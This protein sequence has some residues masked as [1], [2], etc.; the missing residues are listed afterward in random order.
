MKQP[1]RSLLD[2]Q[3][4]RPHHTAVCVEDFDR[5]RAF[6]CD[7]VG[8]HLENE[9]DHRDEKEL[10]IVVG[11][12]GAK[13]RWAM[14]VH[15]HYRIELFRYYVP[16]GK[17]ININ[18]A[19]RGITHIAF[20]VRD[21]DEVYRRVAETDY[22]PYSYPQNLRGG[23]TRPFYVRGPEGIVVEFIQFRETER[24]S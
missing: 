20:E 15:N 9:A 24:Q 17:T 8:M 13:I 5:A 2:D 10:G 19:D 4:I 1:N 22:Q 12:P 7:I 16:S 3:V 6:F 11:H 18:Q 14:L 23:A 21:V